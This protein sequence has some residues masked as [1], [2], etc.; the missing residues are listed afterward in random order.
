M[1]SCLYARLGPV[2]KHKPC[3]ARS[4]GCALSEIERALPA[5]CGLMTG[6]GM[7][8]IHLIRLS[9]PNPRLLDT[10]FCRANHV[11]ALM[12]TDVPSEQRFVHIYGE[13]GTGKTDLL[14]SVARH[15]PGSVL[16][17]CPVTAKGRLAARDSAAATA[18]LDVPLL[19]D[20]PEFYFQQGGLTE[21]VD[22]F[23]RRIRGPLILATQM[24]SDLLLHLGIVAEPDIV[25]CL[26]NTHACCFGV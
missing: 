17:P 21:V 6:N 5:G 26:R 22:Q 11:L 7:V 1:A 24:R 16:I 25:V 2:T 10:C 12:A 9:M 13:T 15:L 8:T 23:T 19:I 18:G 4:N 20:G 3:A 14:H